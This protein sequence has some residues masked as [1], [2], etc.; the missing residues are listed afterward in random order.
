MR[1]RLQRW[2][3]ARAGVARSLLRLVKLLGDIYSRFSL[4]LR[5]GVALKIIISVVEL[6]V[7]VHPT[8]GAFV[9]Q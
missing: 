2:R 1:T 7:R 5:L 4:V 8:G 3:V 9:D 6:L